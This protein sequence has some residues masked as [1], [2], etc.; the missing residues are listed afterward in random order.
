M[1]KFGNLGHWHE[2]GWN[3]QI[4]FS[5]LLLELAMTIENFYIKLKRK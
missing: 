4:F 1:K 2:F 3:L 5:M